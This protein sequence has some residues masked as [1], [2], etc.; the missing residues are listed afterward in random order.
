MDVRWWGTSRT[1]C[2]KERME[3]VSWVRSSSKKPAIVRLLG[4]GAEGQPLGLGKHAHSV[5][6]S[7]GI[8]LI[9]T[10][11]SIRRSSL[12]YVQCG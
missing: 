9:Q 7:F 10:L 6:Y 2:T 1:R 11:P 4:D 8:S 12:I 3:T 5:S